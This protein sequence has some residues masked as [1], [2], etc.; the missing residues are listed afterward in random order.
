[1][2]SEVVGDVAVFA[3]EEGPKLARG[4]DR[5]AVEREDA[6]GDAADGDGGQAAPEVSDE[7]DFLAHGLIPFQLQTPTVLAASRSVILGAYP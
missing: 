6:A 3:S 1:M 7:L 5:A 2:I 4:D